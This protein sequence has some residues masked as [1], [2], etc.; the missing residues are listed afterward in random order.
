MGAG[1]RSLSRP[2]EI[3]IPVQEAL[4][5]SLVTAIYREMGIS[6]AGNEAGVV[7]LSGLVRSTNISKVEAD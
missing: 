6:W 4:R 3:K 7:C 5:V 1:R 2:L